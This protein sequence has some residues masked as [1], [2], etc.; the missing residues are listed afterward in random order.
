MERVATH[1][2]K[3]L[4][5]VMDGSLSIRGL[6]TAPVLASFVFAAKAGYLSEVMD[7]EYKYFSGE[8]LLEGNPVL[9]LRNYML[10]R[11]RGSN[12][13]DRKRQHNYATS[14]LR[15]FVSGQSLK[16]VRTTTSG[17]DFFLNKQ[18][19]VVEDL[20]ELVRV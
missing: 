14:A 8:G 18:R 17:R 5:S 10:K 3:E 19:K 2:M 15:S 1:Y 4:P 13:G 16:N 12:P 7:F 11:T 9:T 6:T 20:K